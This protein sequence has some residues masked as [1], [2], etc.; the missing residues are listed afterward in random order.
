MSAYVVIPLML[1]LGV[2]LGFIMGWIIHYFKVEPFIVT[3]M[4][5][6]F[7]RGV[8]YIISLTSVTIHDEAYRYLA[9]TKL[10]IPIFEMGFGVCIRLVC[11]RA[12]PPRV[13][14]NHVNVRCAMNHP[15]GQSPPG[16]GPPGDPH[17][18]AAGPSSSGG[19]QNALQVLD[20]TVDLALELPGPGSVDESG[21]HVPWS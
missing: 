12:K 7:G 17:G 6:W 15:L 18:R 14:A 11:V 13:H 1:L 21:D 20:L 19:L 3:L 9:L 4:G 2:A 10:H 5:L 8:G 16:T